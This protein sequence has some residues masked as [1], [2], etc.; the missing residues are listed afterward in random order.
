V[1]DPLLAEL[2]CPDGPVADTVEEKRRNL[3]EGNAWEQTVVYVMEEVTGRL[4]AVATVCLDGHPNRRTL[5]P[6]YVRRIGGNPYVNLLVRDA[7]LHNHVLLDGKTRL[8]TA[9]LRGALEAVLRER[10]GRVGELPLV[11]GWVDREN[12]ASLR[13]FATVA[14]RPAKKDALW[15]SPGAG[16]LAQAKHDITVVRPAGKPLPPPP[17]LRAYLPLA[18]SHLKSKQHPLA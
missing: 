4:L 3:L 18:A 8:G 9:A 12:A 6:A 2:V 15:Q 10:P 13:A 11:W 5:Q 17:P 7:R 14:F 16:L 1:G